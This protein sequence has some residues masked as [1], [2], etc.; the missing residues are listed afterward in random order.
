MDHQHVLRQA[1]LFLPDP[2]GAGLAQA[3]QIS[4]V[5]PS[6]RPSVSIWFNF[7]LHDQYTLDPQYFYR[8]RTPYKMIRGAPHPTK[9]PNIFKAS[10]L[11]A[12]AFYKSK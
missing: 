11:W 3:F 12:D 5:R 9:E 10:A 6:V 8:F 7:V 1:V 2:R 4:S